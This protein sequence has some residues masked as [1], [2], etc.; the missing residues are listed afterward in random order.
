[1][2]D[3][4]ADSRT[5]E[6]DFGLHPNDHR[7]ADDDHLATSR[8]SADTTQKIPGATYAGNKISIKRGVASSI[9]ANRWRST[10]SPVAQRCF[11]LLS[12]AN[13]FTLIN[14]KLASQFDLSMSVYNTVKLFSVRTNSRYTLFQSS[15]ASEHPESQTKICTASYCSC[16]PHSET[17][18]FYH[19][20]QNEKGMR[21]LLE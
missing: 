6:K 20:P 3:E 5:P 8:A 4:R 12:L 9:G 11:A 15:V 21:L 18:Q 2:G 16:H 14:E 1:L 13:K 17:F 7:E 19:W 10:D